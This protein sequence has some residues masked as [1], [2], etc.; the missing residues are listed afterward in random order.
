VSRGADIEARDIWLWTP[1]M[2][3]AF[4]NANGAG[5][6]TAQLLIDY[7]ADVNALCIKG[8]NALHV[9][10]AYGSYSLMEQLIMRGG[11][12]A[13][14]DNIGETPLHKA[15]LRGELEIVRLLLRHG[16]DPSV[17]STF[18][19]TPARLAAMQNSLSEPSIEHVIVADCLESL[20]NGQATSQLGTVAV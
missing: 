6:E 15:A 10:A 20:A 8:T 12:L 2:S 14:S 17:K 7:G 16:A 9:C 13:Q 19:Y 3:A 11:D 18:G 5:P 4:G 1:L